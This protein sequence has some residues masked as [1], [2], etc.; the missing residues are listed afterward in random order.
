MNIVQ[1]NE[2]Y[3]SVV[4]GDISKSLRN[5]WIKIKTI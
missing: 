3:I 4:S 5:V 1:A 2:K